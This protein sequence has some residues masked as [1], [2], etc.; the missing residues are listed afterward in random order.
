MPE[1]R[2]WLQ[3]GGTFF[4]TV[5]SFERRPFFADPPAPQCLRQALREIRNKHPFQIYAMVLLPEHLHCVWSLPPGD[6]DFSMRW[7]LIKKRFDRLWLPPNAKS[8]H[9]VWQ[10]RF[11][12]HCVRNEKDLKR[13]VDYI[14]WNPVK[15]GHVA[16]ACDWPYSTFARFVKM[17]EYDINWG[18]D[19]PATLANWTVPQE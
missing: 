1:Y 16:R 10:P 8:P 19:E 14:H 17:G 13:H 4:F 3:P 18:Q 11:W 12:E 9:Q 2:R 5:V 6:T 7:E 15:H